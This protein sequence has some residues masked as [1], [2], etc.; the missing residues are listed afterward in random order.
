M[1]PRGRIPGLALPAAGDQRTRSAGQR[2]L[3]TLRLWALADDRQRVLHLRPRPGGPGLASAD[4]RAPDVDPG[5]KGF[6]NRRA[7]ATVAVL[8]GVGCAGRGEPVVRRTHA[9]SDG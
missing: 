8:T 5:R 3:R 4:A 9:P 2:H 6:E 1:G 7:T